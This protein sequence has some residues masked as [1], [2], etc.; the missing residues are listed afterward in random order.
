MNN[1]WFYALDGQQHGPVQ[2]EDL[3]SLAQAGI[4]Q[5][6]DYVWSPGM[7]D[8]GVAHD[9]GGIFERSP[10]PS[11]P[12]LPGIPRSAE[13]D[14]LAKKIAGGLCGVLFGGFGVHKFVI[15]LRKQG[16]TMLLVSL[17]TFF[18]AFPVMQIIGMIEGIIYLAK[19]E[20]DFY[21][22]YV[23]EKRGWF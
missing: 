22:D 21:R 11:P 18:V 23:V 9:I 5:P 15:G 16:M 3:R 20:E 7:A 8:W 14:V 2:L 4:L 1:Q 13:A 12:P 19:T 17:C 10:Q 6:S